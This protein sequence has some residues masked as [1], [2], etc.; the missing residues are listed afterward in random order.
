M[1]EQRETK[2]MEET[3]EKADRKFAKRLTPTTFKALRIVESFISD[4]KL[5]CY[6]GMAINNIL[7][8][9]A[10]FYGRREFPDYDFFSNDALN[11]AKKLADIYY[12]N[13]FKN[14]EAKSGVH[15]GTYKVYVNFFNIADI[16]QLDLGFFTNIQKKSIKKRKIL[17]APP[18]FLRM[19]LY[20]EFSRPKG[21]T[22]RW[23]KLL[24][25]LNL[26]N[27]YY[28]IK[29]KSCQLRDSEKLTNTEVEIYD[30]I[31]EK[32]IHENVI[33]FG[34]FADTQ[35]HKYTRSKRSKSKLACVDVLSEDAK[36]TVES[37]EKDI[38]EYNPR[39]DHIKTI[40]EL[41]PEH[42]T[43]TIN[44][45]IYSFIFQTEACYTYNRLKIKGKTIN[46]ATIFT[47]MSLY[48]TF[49][50]N[51]DKNYNHDRILCTAEMLN[52]IYLKNR[53]SRKG[54]LRNY[55]VNC[56]GEQ[57]TLEDILSRKTEIYKN[58]K[59]GDTKYDR[60]FLRY[61]PK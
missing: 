35:Y 18:D 59:K 11:D 55:T 25:R 40:G 1:A 49:I 58:I 33:F 31:K 51:D 8:K 53:G 10:Q 41:I 61:V 3:V 39:I 45:R 38:S 57:E 34:G 2:L 28:P 15:E 42:Y 43:I 50:Y 27:R 4:N 5:V 22:S 20:L 17:Y 12:K 52:S 30:K 6:G 56:M 32:L 24:P 7:P 37:I 14:V 9:K 21:D 36:K 46:I 16:T 44:N 26:L 60:Y 54:I 23:E 13:G 48:L 47:M 29:T 19:S